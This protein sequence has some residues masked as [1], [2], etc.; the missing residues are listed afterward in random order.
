[1]CWRW[2]WDKLNGTFNFSTANIFRST[3]PIE[4]AKESMIAELKK[5]LNTVINTS[6][7]QREI[8]TAY[9]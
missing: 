5:P 4:N 2:R 8:R 9:F 3:K 1:M 6:Y 7:T